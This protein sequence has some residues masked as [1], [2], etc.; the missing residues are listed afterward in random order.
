WP[1]NIRQLENVVH[2]MVVF[3]AHHEIPESV[4][5]P[6]IA[7]HTNN[8]HSTSYSTLPRNGAGSHELT[9]MENAE[10][11]MIT[12]ALATAAGNVVR[13]AG[14]LGLGQATVYRKMK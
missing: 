14:I 10:K 13:A 5:P 8:H 7:H 12:H 11:Q 3:A 6:E 2:R 1:G 4:L 9:A